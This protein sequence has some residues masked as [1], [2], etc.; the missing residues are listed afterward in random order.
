MEILIVREPVSLDVLQQ[1]AKAWY[2]DLV[3]GVVDCERGIAALGGDWH[4]DANVV[5]IA[6]GS[7]Q[8]DV[9]GFNVYLEKR[10]SAALEYSSL[11]NIRPA[12]ANREMELRDESLRLKIR[13]I[14]KNIMPDLGL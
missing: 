5:L 3:K 1:L 10:G 13:E 6:D 8:E 7:R 12:Q 2:G 9:G 4:M 14:L 11:I